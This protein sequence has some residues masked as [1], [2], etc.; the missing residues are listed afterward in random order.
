MSPGES[1]I[2]RGELVSVVVPVYRVQEYLERCVDS[3]VAQSHAKLEIILVDDG[4]PDRCG[5]LCDAYA[6]RDIRVRVIHQP[7]AGLSAARNAGMRIARGEYLAFVDSDDWVHEEY[8]ATLLRLVHDHDADISMCLFSW[9]LSDEVPPVDPE[10]EVRVLSPR[11]VLALLDGPLDM[12]VAV[13]WGKLYR[14]SLFE[15]I[16]YPVGRTHEDDYTTHRLLS[17]ARRTALTSAPLY[18]YR[19]RPGSIMA[20]HG[21][22]NL[23]DQGDALVRRAAFLTDA[24]LD[25]VASGQLRK[26]FNILRRLRRAV[27]PDDPWSREVAEQV[28]SVARALRRSGRPWPLRLY[29]A[30]Y[31]RF[32]DAMDRLHDVY[33]TVKGRFRPSPAGHH[34]VGTTS[35]T[36]VSSTVVP[37][38][39]KR[40][41]G[42][43]RTPPYG[44]TG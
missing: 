34:M 37:P 35:F 3:L 18:H 19:L 2:G 13:A 42:D 16:E 11:E 12:A 1:V 5:E 28:R 17:R 43:R 36:G 9:T 33:R 30:A 40:R 26:A 27:P 15:G 7:N 20:T 38:G 14:R 23:R 8:V 31:I 32:P 22:V 29:A 39:R 24:G 25:R 6:A 10:G 44:R 41:P 4:S 21:I